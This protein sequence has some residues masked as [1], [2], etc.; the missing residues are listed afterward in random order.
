MNK[1]ITIIGMGTFGIEI[2]LSLMQAGVAVCAIDCNAEIIDSIK[3]QVSLAIVMDTTQEKTLL[4]A[5][6]QEM[7]TVVVAIGADNLEN[8]ILTTALL[9]QIRVENIIARA[10]SDLHERILRKVGASMVINPEKE[11]G[12]RVAKH[13]LIPGFM[14]IFSLPG[15]NCIAQ[16]PMPKEFAGYTLNELA[17]RQRYNI[18]VLGIQRTGSKEE[19]SRVNKFIKKG[20]ELWSFKNYLGLTAKLDKSKIIMNISPDNDRFQDGDILFVMGKEDD[21]NSCFN[22]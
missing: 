1:Q 14:E 5:K 6:V 4:D 21:I 12:Q 16:I 17:V 22:R 2:A 13:I 19:L 7:D 10:T 3:E 20:K 15:D 9:R 8:S 18:T 11:M